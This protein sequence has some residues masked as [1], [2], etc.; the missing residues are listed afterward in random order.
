MKS[1]V[2]VLVFLVSQNAAANTG[3]QNSVGKI[4]ALLSSSKLAQHLDSQI[5]DISVKQSYLNGGTEYY[6]TIADSKPANEAKG[7]WRP[8]TCSLV[9]QVVPVNNLFEVA[10]IDF[11]GC[12]LVK[13]EVTH[14]NHFAMN[15]EQL[16]LLLESKDLASM[17]SQLEIT[18]IN[19][20]EQLSNGDAVYSIFSA[21]GFLTKVKI[22]N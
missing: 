5:V 13:S 1:L 16:N 18:G 11:S 22:Q 4:K 10:Q 7:Y 8:K 14:P 9:V 21:A 17:N 20:S 6:L 12:E 2:A 19:L 15:V 3:F